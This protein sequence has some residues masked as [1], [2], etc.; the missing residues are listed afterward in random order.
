MSGLSRIEMQALHAT[1][2]TSTHLGEILKTLEAMLDYQVRATASLSRIADALEA[3][4][5]RAEVSEP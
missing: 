4:M 3:R 1:A 5:E 2:Q